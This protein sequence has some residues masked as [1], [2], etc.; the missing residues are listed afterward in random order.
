MA[1]S[2]QAC[3]L[4]GVPIRGRQSWARLLPE[5]RESGGGEGG[6]AHAAPRIGVRHGPQEGRAIVSSD[7]TSTLN[8]TSGQRSNASA[9]V[10]G[11]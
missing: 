4:L 2:D 11:A 7:F 10:I 5:P 9:S 6:G 1:P 3:H 8:R